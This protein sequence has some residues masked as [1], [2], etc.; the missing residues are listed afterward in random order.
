VALHEELYHKHG[1]PTWTP[2]VN[3]TEVGPSR[4]L[5]PP[6]GEAERKHRPAP[7]VAA[8]GGW[9]EL[10]ILQR[11]YQQAD[12]ATMLKVVLEAGELREARG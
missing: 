2:I 11:C 12:G 4:P 9:K 10:T 7:D 8:A 1:R 5:T 6:L 3:G